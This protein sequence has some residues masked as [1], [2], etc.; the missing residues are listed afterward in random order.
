MIAIVY[1]HGI[2]FISFEY[3]ASLFESGSYFSTLYFVQYSVCSAILCA[4]HFRLILAIAL[5]GKLHFFFYFILTIKS[6]KCFFLEFF[7]SW[8]NLFSNLNI[9]I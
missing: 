2:Q 3:E 9:P 7:Y 4:S 6:P 1:N 8:I 5:H